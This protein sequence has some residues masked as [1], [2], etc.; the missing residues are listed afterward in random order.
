MK[1][2][3]VAITIRFPKDMA[4]TIRE[5]ATDNRRSFNSEVVSLAEKAIAPEVAV[6]KRKLLAS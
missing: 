3:E 4:D 1:N 5:L 6:S 2:D